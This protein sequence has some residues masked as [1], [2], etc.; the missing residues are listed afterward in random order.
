M[1]H[2]IWILHKNELLK[3]KHIIILLD[4]VHFKLIINFINSSVYPF[5]LRIGA[6]D[7]DEYG[8]KSGCS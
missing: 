7:K 8:M 4:V 2:F 1:F 3:K 6:R 5:V